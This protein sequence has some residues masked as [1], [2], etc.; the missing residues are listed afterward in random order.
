MKQKK[1]IKNVKEL[2][3]GGYYTCEFHTPLG[4]TFDC[5]AFFVKEI[6]TE[7]LVTIILDSGKVEKTTITDY[8]ESLELGSY[9]YYHSD[10]KYFI[11]KVR[12]S[13]S[14]LRKK[15]VRLS[16]KTKALDRFI[17]TLP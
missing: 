3:E 5:P 10:K 14:R 2:K 8:K 9:S 12:R 16:R 1:H 11:R 6:A 4:S 17:D 15:I 13:R 7:G